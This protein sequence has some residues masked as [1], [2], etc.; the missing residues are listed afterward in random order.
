MRARRPWTRLLAFLRERPAPVQADVLW[1]RPVRYPVPARRDDGWD[2]NRTQ[3]N[4]P[5]AR[6]YAGGTREACLR[7]PRPKG[8]AR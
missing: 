1:Q 2:E 8:G 3:L 4:I 7:A 6:P 5:I